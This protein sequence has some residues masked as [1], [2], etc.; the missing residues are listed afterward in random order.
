M[1]LKK[2][3]K[4]KLMLA[5]LF[6]LLL[7][8]ASSFASGGSTFAAPITDRVALL[9]LQLGVL[10]FLASLGKR[11]ATLLGYP[12]VLGEVLAGIIIGPFALGAI[13]LPGLPSGLF[14]KTIGFPISSDLY[15]VASLGAIVLLF[16]SGL[17]TDTTLLRKN[18]LSGSLVAIG[19]A[20]V[21]F[22]AGAAT[23]A[24]FSGLILGEPLNILSTPCLL[25]GVIASATSVG[26]TARILSDEG[27]LNEGE[28]VTVVAGAVFDDIIGIVLL[29]SILSLVGSRSGNEGL[30]LHTTLYVAFATTLTCLVVS[31]VGFLMGP[32]LARLLGWFDG[33]ATRAAVSLSVAVVVS[34]LFAEAGLAMIIGAYVIGLAL[35]R[36]PIAASLDE[37]L[38]PIAE[39]FVPLFFATT[40]MLVKLNQ[41]FSIPVLSFGLVY[42]FVAIVAKAGGCSIAARWCGFNDRS[43][44]IIGCGMIPRGEVAL[45]IA[46]LAFSSGLLHATHFGAAVM[47]AVTTMI[48]GPMM[49]RQVI[50]LERPDWLANVVHKI[51]ASGHRHHLPA[52][53]AALFVIFVS[54]AIFQPY[55]GAVTDGASLPALISGTKGI[56]ITSLIVDGPSLWSATRDGRLLHVS[57][58]KVV[59]SNGDPT[60]P[61]LIKD[62][63]LSGIHIW[64]AAGVDGLLRLDGKELKKLRPPFATDEL[65]I[66]SLARGTD[67]L[68]IGTSQGLFSYDLVSWSTYPHPQRAHHLNIT[69]LLAEGD[70]MFVG[71]T[72]GLFQFNGQWSK[73]PLPGGQWPVTVLSDDESGAIYC[74][75]PRGLL[76]LSTTSNHITFVSGIEGTVSSIAAQTNKI[77]VG[78]D[79]GL[80]TGQADAKGVTVAFAKWLGQVPV[81]AITADRD[82]LWVGT[83]KGLA[84]RKL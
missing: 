69:S 26:L 51:N 32:T 67:R 65:E 5:I 81:T 60:K 63:V 79:R 48:V 57:D 38:Q 12:P 13:A 43:A 22:I 37:H 64:S 78:T 8:G 29:A 45:Y 84:K 2:H 76:R 77:F 30:L 40:G 46:C 21:P 19:G 61:L 25:L 28:G 72:E 41:M 50:A 74:G 80:Y 33:S 52:Y 62:L 75:G 44:A 16:S 42:A 24:L 1:S 39:V 10:L 73:V 49:L 58:G 11:G 55:L 71:T 9:A 83:T 23:A 27:Q 18:W 82:N 15:G 47:M 34:A 3:S 17:R 4:T 36:T 54:A 6:L 59:E 66:T 35:A 14:P 56:E 20:I 53:A 7:N 68:W 31:L 70:I